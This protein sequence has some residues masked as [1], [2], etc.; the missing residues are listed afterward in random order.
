MRVI[1][2]FIP[3]QLQDM[4]NKAIEEREEK[5]VSK[6]NIYMKVLPEFKR[7]F[8]ETKEISRKIYMCDPSRT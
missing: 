2:T 1:N 6:K 5:Y 3:D 8:D 4:I 7:L